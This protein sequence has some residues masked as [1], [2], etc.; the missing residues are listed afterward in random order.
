[1]MNKD[2]QYTRIIYYFNIYILFR[3]RKKDPLKRIFYFGAY[4]PPGQNIYDIT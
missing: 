3:I 1:M 2:F 4:T